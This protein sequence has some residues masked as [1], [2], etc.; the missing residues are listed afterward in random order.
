MED[1]I[2]ISIS[3]TEDGQEVHLEFSDE[4]EVVFDI[5]A[6]SDEFDKLC[7]AYLETMGY[8]IALRQVPINAT[9]H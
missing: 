2:S 8:E 5:F 4:Q 7:I 3:V 6:D 1:N 9:V